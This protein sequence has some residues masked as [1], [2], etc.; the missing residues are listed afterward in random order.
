MYS[1]Q[2]EVCILL[3]YQAEAAAAAADLIGIIADTLQTHLVLMRSLSLS[4]AETEAAG[5]LNWPNRSIH[6]NRPSWLN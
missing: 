1:Y 2:S 3:N 4:S 5:V 6:R